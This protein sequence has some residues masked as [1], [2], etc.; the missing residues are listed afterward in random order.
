MTINL[1]QEELELTIKTITTELNRCKH[2]YG[3]DK[4]N[5][6]YRTKITID[7]ISTF[8]RL[9]SIYKSVKSKDDIESALEAIVN[10]G[11]TPIPIH[12]PSRG[13]YEYIKL[14]SNIEQASVRVKSLPKKMNIVCTSSQNEDS[15]FRMLYQGDIK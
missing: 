12:Q 4:N 13:N 14:K 1:T 11:K 10:L 9:L 7:K 3:Y 8:E 2:N 15:R 5:V 6:P